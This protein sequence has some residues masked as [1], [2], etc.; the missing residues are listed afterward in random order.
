MFFKLQQMTGNT[1]MDKGL[2]LINWWRVFIS[3]VC[4]CVCVRRSPAHARGGMRGHRFRPAPST[5]FVWEIKNVY[6]KEHSLVN[7]VFSHKRNHSETNTCTPT[8][9]FTER[10]ARKSI[11]SFSSIRTSTATY[12]QD[13]TLWLVVQRVPRQVRN[14]VNTVS[15]AEVVRIFG[16]VVQHSDW[17]NQLGR[18]L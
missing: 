12:L 6:L 9:S 14:T 5:L 7:L 11:F 17:Q 3:C 15:G 8:V 4:A 16:Q 1:L 2:L 10:R 18:T 13:W